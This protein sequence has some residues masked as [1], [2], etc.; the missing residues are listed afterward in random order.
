METNQLHT[1]DSFITRA[2]KSERP[3]ILSGT[4]R[5]NIFRCPMRSASLDQ[6]GFAIEITMEA[7]A[8]SAPAN[9][10]ELLTATTIKI[11]ANESIEIGIRPM[12]PEIENFI[13]PGVRNRVVYAENMC[14]ILLQG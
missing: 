4:T 5:I 11:R 2:I 13:A 3:R 12:R 1:G 10:Y 14:H 8:L 7:T 6:N 9:A